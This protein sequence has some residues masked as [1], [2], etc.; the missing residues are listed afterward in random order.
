MYNAQSLVQALHDADATGDVTIIFDILPEET[1]L[2]YARDVIDSDVSND[3]GPSLLN[4]IE[5]RFETLSGQKSAMNIV[6]YVLALSSVDSLVYASAQRVV[7]SNAHSLDLSTAKKVCGLFHERYKNEVVAGDQFIAAKALEGAVMLALFRNDP[8]LLFLAIGLLLTEFPPI[9][10]SVED[11]SD[12]AVL[13]LRLLGRCYDHQPDNPSI[14][15][16]IHELITSENTAVHLAAQFNA[17]IVNFYDAFRS[18]DHKSLVIKLGAARNDFELVSQQGENQADAELLYLVCDCFL[19]LMDAGSNEEYAL[20]ARQAKRILIERLLLL[21]NDDNPYGSKLETSMI[22]IL[23]LLADWE[24]HLSEAIY[25]PDLRVPMSALAEIYTTIREFD[26]TENVT[27]NLLHSTLDLVMLPSVRSHFIQIQEVRRKVLTV[28]NDPIWRQAAQPTE[29]AFYETVWSEITRNSDPKALAAPQL[30]KLV[31]EAAKYKPQLASYMQNAFRDGKDVIDVLADVLQREYEPA[32]FLAE[33]ERSIVQNLVSEFRMKVPTETI[34]FKF[35]E[36]AIK[37][38][39]HYAYSLFI[40]NYE[41]DLAFLFATPSGLGIKAAEKDLE[42]HFYKIMRFSATSKVEKQPP[43]IAPGRPDLCYRFPDDIIFPIEVKREET[44]ISFD[45][46]RQNY[47][48]QAQTY[49]TS[50][51][52]ISF[53]F[54]LDVT[55]KKLGIP[56]RNFRDHFKIDQFILQESAVQDYVIVVVFPA[57]RVRPSDHSWKSTEGK[58][59]TK[60]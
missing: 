6:I 17:G 28:L 32:T 49:A 22:A 10:V 18:A 11:A 15:K 43:G 7:L 57:N 25:A 5:R 54:V 47:L 39:V 29:I 40:S 12:L 8:G 58:R 30:D 20:K 55:E 21:G 56:I 36:Q 42:T 48:A 44:D 23:S 53:L 1:I 41:A 27:M 60:R 26:A 59:K 37:E 50:Q 13:A 38:T 51:S 4:A 16:K 9:P 3:V 34:M 2:R 19:I 31:E 52:G 33:P 45:N 14:V 46:I 35:L 24:S